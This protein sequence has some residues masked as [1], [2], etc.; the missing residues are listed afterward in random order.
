MD[1][2]SREMELGAFGKLTLTH[3]E[4]AP[5]IENEYD[6]EE[7]LIFVLTA[8]LIHYYTVFLSKKPCATRFFRFPSHALVKT[9]TGLPPLTDI[10]MLLQNVG[11]GYL[12]VGLYICIQSHSF[13]YSD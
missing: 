7:Q 3:E 12:S 2:I 8:A 4:Q 6:G 1:G 5:E 10:S 13:A 11:H 9:Q